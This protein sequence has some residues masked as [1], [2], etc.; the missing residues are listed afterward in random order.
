[1]AQNGIEYQIIGNSSDV[2]ERRRLWVV[3]L[4]YYY[5]AVRKEAKKAKPR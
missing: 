2:T 5:T 1:M 4:A 3:V